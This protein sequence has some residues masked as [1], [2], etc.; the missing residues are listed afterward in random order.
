MVWVFLI[1]VTL[2]SLGS[3]RSEMLQTQALGVASRGLVFLLSFVKADLILMYFLELHHSSRAWREG[4]RLSLFLL[5]VI[6][7]GLGEV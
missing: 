6:L 5:I 4:F 2:L 1:F 3:A 7:Y